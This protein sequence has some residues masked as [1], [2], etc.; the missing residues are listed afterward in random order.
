MV[1]KIVEHIAVFRA[2]LWNFGG[3]E[4]ETNYLV[5]WYTEVVGTRVNVGRRVPSL[6]PSGQ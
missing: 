3:G 6:V 4:G 5:N 1:R 2:L